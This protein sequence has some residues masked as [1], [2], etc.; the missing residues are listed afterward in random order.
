MNQTDKISVEYGTDPAVNGLG[1]MI[2][3]YLEQNLAEFEDKVRQ[4]RKLHI[5][6]SVEVEKGISTTIKFNGDE[7]TI[8]NGVSA[9]TDLHLNSSYATLAD[10][11]S[12]KANPVKSVI[13]GKIKIKKFSP[14][15]PFQSMRML[16]FLKIPQELLIEGRKNQ[17]RL[18]NYRSVII[19][20]SGLT[21]GFAIA[22]VFAALGWI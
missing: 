21:G 22:Y 3:Q 10:I 2:G 5:S 20:L 12:G 16:N 11:L 13:S 17:K 14:S 18:L 15:K 9:D 1:M 6:A 7:I 4:G 19:F 8:K